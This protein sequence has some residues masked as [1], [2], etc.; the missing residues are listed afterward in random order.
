[1]EWLKS[2]LVWGDSLMKGIVFNADENKYSICPDN[3]AECV[4]R[5]MEIEV[6]NRARFG[7]T[8]PRGKSLLIK[9]LEKGFSADAA[10]IEFG[11]N[12]CD[13]NWAEVSKQP[14]DKHL[15]NTPLERFRAE[16][17]HMI[18]ILRLNSII[19]VLMS[20]P[21]IDSE[22]YFEF[23]T[24]GGLDKDNIK[25]FLG[26]IAHIYRWQELYS[27]TVTNIAM[28]TNC[29]YIDVRSVFLTEWDYRN[30]LCEDGIHL[31]ERG[32][33]LMGDVFEEYIHR[34]IQPI[35]A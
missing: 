26:D 22:R 12:D 27:H 13:I 2:V 8:A 28:E 33:R 14:H 9:D 11:G 15:S 3:S 1:M 19:P 7:C 30:Y 10:L 5:E 24:R 32:Q 17:I 25:T 16:M 18:K 31:N 4:G 34:R 35:S 23:I 20:I 29:R 21:P 6:M